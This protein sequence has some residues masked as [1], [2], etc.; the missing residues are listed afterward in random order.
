[1]IRVVIADDHAVV[2]EGIKRIISDAGDMTVVAEAGDGKELLTQLEAG[3]CDVVLLDLAMPGTPG[4]QILQDVRRRY[5]QISVLILTMYPQDQY[6]V[7]TLI[8]GASGYVHKG[9]PPDE[10]I[11]AVRTVAAGRR[12]ITA[13]AAE[14]L[15]SHVD[16]VSPKAPHE[17]LSNREYQVLCLIASG[18]SVGEVAA[19]LSLSV[20]TISTYRGRILEKLGLRHNA[21]IIRYAMQHGLVD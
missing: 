4:L 17:S 15:A 7:R 18:K 21:E 13:E 8:A 2:R 14:H 12:Y 16:T 1:M 6:A 3:G 19:E 10:L 5:P 20:K 9:D 11:V